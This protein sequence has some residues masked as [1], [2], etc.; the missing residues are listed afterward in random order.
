MP[1]SMPDDPQ[2]PE[3][4][5]DDGPDASPEPID[6]LQPLF[7]EEP[8]R[9]EG[10]EAPPMWLW[11]LIFGTILFGTFY[12]GS[13]LGDFSPD[14]WL[15]SSKP[16]AQAGQAPVEEVVSGSSIYGSRCA[17][18][19]QNNGEGVTNAF[20]PLN[21]V[22]WVE[23]KGQIIRILLQGLQ[24]P[25]EVRGST[26]NGNMPAWGS[27]LSDKEIAAVIT[28]VR[29]SW[30]N[31]FTEVTADEVAAV[32]EATQARTQPWTAEELVEDANRTVPVDG[33]ATAARRSAPS[34]GE[35]LFAQVAALRLNGGG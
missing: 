19:H 17:N 18:C 20:P 1:P 23:D 31:D 25:I 22:R 3:P 14:P 28:H 6:L 11:M 21:R 29:Q 35:A 5:P 30:E 12:L 16:V 24:G 26:Y 15:Q 8:L 13:Y 9:P 33:G 27:V 4:T 10:A 2:A 32:R 34:L 7:R